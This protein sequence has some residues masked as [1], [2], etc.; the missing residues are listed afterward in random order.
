MIQN[1]REYIERLVACGMTRSAA[2]DLCYYHAAAGGEAEL[3]A[4]VSAYED[5]AGGD[6]DGVSAV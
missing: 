6:V 1:G 4:I 5:A 3:E 2:T